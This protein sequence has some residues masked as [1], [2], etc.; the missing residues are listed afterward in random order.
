LRRFLNQACRDAGVRPFRPSLSFRQ[1]D[2]APA[3]RNQIFLTCRRF[4]HCSSPICGW[5]RT[6][7]RG[8]AQASTG[9]EGLL[10]W[11]GGAMPRL[12][13]VS[14][15]CAGRRC[16]AWLSSVA[17]AFR[18]SSSASAQDRARRR[19]IPRLP[20]RL[21]ISD[22]GNKGGRA[23]RPNSRDRGQAVRSF[24]CPSVLTPR[25]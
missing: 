3:C 25:G 10:V 20:E 24:L 23:R 12:H 1:P 8:V 21:T 9:S 22:G 5:K 18:L 13:H 7:R 4:R 17:A 11:R 16:P 19:D 15:T 2:M 14:A 6:P